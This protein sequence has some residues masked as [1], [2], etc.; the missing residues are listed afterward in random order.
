M[1]QANP[2][3]RDPQEPLPAQALSESDTAIARVLEDL[4]DILITRGVIQFTDLP[5]A[6]QG[7]LLNRRQTRAMLKDPL[8]LLPGEGDGGLL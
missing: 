8:Q 7:K 4:I 1:T 6:A 5:E 3:E 2:P